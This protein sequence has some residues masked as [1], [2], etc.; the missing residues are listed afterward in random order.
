MNYRVIF[1]EN[2][3]EDMDSIVEYLIIH[4]RNKQAASHFVDSVENGKSILSNSA[5][6]FQLCLNSKLQSMG[7]RKLN[8]EKTKY[9][10]LYR[11]EN[12]AVFV[13]GIY[14]Q[15]QDYE[16]KIK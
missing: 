14:H 10:L 5:D 13:D 15:L 11:I 6:S 1:T 7:Y 9:F 2:A 4:L 12:S 8:L 3:L 16:N